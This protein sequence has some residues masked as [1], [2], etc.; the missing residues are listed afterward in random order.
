MK[1]AILIVAIIICCMPSSAIS[2]SLGMTT[3][4]FMNTWEPDCYKPNEPYMF[5]TDVDSFNMAVDEFNSYLSQVEQYMLCVETEAETDKRAM[6]KAVDQGML[7]ATEGIL[8]EVQ[9][10]RS[11]LEASRS[12]LY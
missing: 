11:T 2:G 10:A 6:I 4:G 1:K 8:M 5:I 7:E 9:S 12:T 3:I